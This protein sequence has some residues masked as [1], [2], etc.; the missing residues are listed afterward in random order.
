MFGAHVSVV[1]PETENGAKLM[2]NANVDARNGTPNPSPHQVLG[3]GP[4][5]TSHQSLGPGPLPASGVGS[6]THPRI[7]IGRHQQP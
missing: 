2:P 6:R 1:T 5:P 3:P 4:I 7:S